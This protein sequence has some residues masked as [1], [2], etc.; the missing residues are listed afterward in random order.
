MVKELQHNILFTI[1]TFGY[2]YQYPLVSKAKGLS[3][4]KDKN[5][6]SR[7]MYAMCANNVSELANDLAELPARIEL[8]IHPIS[9]S[10]T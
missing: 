4:R 10:P 3:C 8:G 6:S 9:L 2:Y 5:T 7:C 1:L